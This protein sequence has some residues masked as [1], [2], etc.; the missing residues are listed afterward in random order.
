[1]GFSNVPVTQDDTRVLCSR[2]SKLH[3]GEMSVTTVMGFTKS[4]AQAF[5][6]VRRRMGTTALRGVIRLY[7]GGR[8]CKLGKEVPCARSWLALQP[9]VVAVPGSAAP[10]LCDCGWIESQSAGSSQSHLAERAGGTGG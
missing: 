9:M 4:P 5:G 8:F 3:G 2:L 10:W 6:S 7:G 1:M